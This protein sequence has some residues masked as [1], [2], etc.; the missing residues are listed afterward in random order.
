METARKAVRRPAA[1]PLWGRLPAR[2]RILY[3]ATPSRIGGWLAESFAADSA[4][5]VL[6][7]QAMGAAAGMARLREDA[8]DAVLIAHDPDALDALDT[9]E[10]LRTGGAEEPVV[11]LGAEC[12]TDVAPLAYEAGADAYV[13]VHST[14]TRALLWTIARAMERCQLVREN[15]RLAVAENHRLELEHGEVDR[16]L[17]QQRALVHDLE[18]LSEASASARPRIRPPSERARHEASFALPS[19]LLDHYRELL[20]AYVIMGA[21]N[22]AEEMA[23]LAD[24]LAD[25]GV[26][27]GQTIELHLQALEELVRGLGNRSARHVMTRADLLA[28]EI[29]VHLAECYRRRTFEVRQD[30]GADELPSTLEFSSFGQA[31]SR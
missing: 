19:P 9:V 25:G 10:V 15:R 11:V 17:E 14:T 1:E 23:A 13:C 5:D 18:A 4:V 12:E 2:M 27:A 29:V 20:R 24:V 31:R 6:L 22:L 7:E 8:F 26:S 28:L 3:V 16:L 30:R 21:G